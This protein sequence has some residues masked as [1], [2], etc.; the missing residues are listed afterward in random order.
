[1]VEIKR[2]RSEDP[3]I[4]GGEHL[5]A[6]QEGGNGSSYSSSGVESAYIAQQYGSGF[7]RR[8]ACRSLRSA[9]PASRSFIYTGWNGL[10][11]LA[12]ILSGYEPASPSFARRE[13][14]SDGEAHRSYFDC[15]SRKGHRPWRTKPYP[16]HVVTLKG[17]DGCPR[18]FR[19]FPDGV[20][21]GPTD[22][23]E[24]ILP[25]IDQKEVRVLPTAAASRARRG[26]S[27][28]RE[29]SECRPWSA[30]DSRRLKL[31]KHA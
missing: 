14:K 6:H 8:S 28:N 10:R 25:D 31:E 29:L 4:E 19:S 26:W 22:T 5:A 20:E 16:A 27:T 18:R 13:F 11:N 7:G 17:E 23:Y 21:R 3:R 1:M 24:G 30:L 9:R 12:T 15:P 2:I